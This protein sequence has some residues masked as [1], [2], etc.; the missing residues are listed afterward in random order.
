M[1]DDVMKT[2]DILLR[3]FPCR[4]RGLKRVHLAILTDETCKK[5]RVIAEMHPNIDRDLGRFDQAQKGLRQRVLVNAVT[6]DLLADG[7]TLDQREFRKVERRA[8]P[9]G[10]GWG[11]QDAAAAQLVCD[12]PAG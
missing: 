9:Y 10:A 8:P 4:G 7:F 5:R 3:N 2:S 12:K 1:D 11:R 6:V